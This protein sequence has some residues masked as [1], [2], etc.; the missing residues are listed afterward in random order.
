MIDSPSSTEPAIDA[1]SA[2]TEERTPDDLVAEHARVLRERVQ[3]Q[4]TVA[5]L[6]AAVGV[7]REAIEACGEGG[8]GVH[9]D[10]VVE[11]DCAVTHYFDAEIPG[12][13]GW[14]WCAVLAG[15][16]GGDEV[17]VSEI[18]LLPG[19]GALTAPAWV[20]WTERVR[21]GDLGPG[22]VLV[23]PPDDPRLV[24]GY[25]DNADRTPVD[26][27][28]VSEVMLEVGLGRKRLLSGDG[29]SQAAARWSGGEYGPDSEMAH[30]TRLHCHSCGF[31]VPVTGA[32]RAEFGVC[33]NEFAADGRV[34]HS[35]Y[36]CGAHSDAVV[37]VDQATVYP[38]YDDGA[39][40]VV[41]VTAG[42]PA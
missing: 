27:P 5:M 22:D 37:H 28:Q 19:S 18:A 26:D 8:V 39:V 23:S 35:E 25:L 36:G 7:A 40:E 31:F 15:Y 2:R 6:A 41:E 13:R 34:V 9:L 3:R 20:P 29:R 24:P 10:A 38:P 16:P 4:D 12:Y 1:A 30:S 42:S 21:A 11:G 14:H 32:L 17:T 33:T